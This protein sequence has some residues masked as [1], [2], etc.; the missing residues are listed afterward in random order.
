MFWVLCVCVL[1]IYLFIVIDA[2]R[3][4]GYGWDWFIFS[5]GLRSESCFEFWSSGFCVCVCVCFFFFFFVL[6][7]PMPKGRGGYSW[8]W[9]RL[10][11]FL[12]EI[13]GFR[14][15][16]FLVGFW[17]WIGAV[18]GASSVAP[19]VGFWLG[20]NWCF[21]LW[22]IWWICYLFLFIFFFFLC[23]RNTI[24]IPTFSSYSHFGL[25]FLF[26]PLLVIIL[27]NVFHFGLY[28][29]LSNGNILR[30]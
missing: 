5:G 7:W 2:Y 18:C 1:F 6:S 15:V 30:G 16:G 19:M 8:D 21:D 10:V 3:R 20:L 9:W 26:L 4:G 27:K 25:Y 23:G 12:V 24:F 28:C 14:L 22:V 29:Y 13:S 11:G 17:V